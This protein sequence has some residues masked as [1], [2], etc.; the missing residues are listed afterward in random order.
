MSSPQDA[1]VTMVKNLKI[2]FGKSLEEWIKDVNKKGLTKHGDILKYLKTEHGFTH[3]YANLVSMKARQTDAGSAES[4]DLVTDQY[5]GDK[6]NLKPIYDALINEIKKFGSDVDFAPKKAYVS[7]R[8]KKQFAIIQPSTKTRVDVG[9][10]FKDVPPKGRLERSGSF[11][12]MVSH[13]VKVSDKKEVDK[14][15]ISWLKQAYEESRHVE[16]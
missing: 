13:R 8:R 3:G 6:S 15:L 11:N 7:I 2:K 16:T 10:N 5:S 12:T 4:D 14:D 9:I 1:E